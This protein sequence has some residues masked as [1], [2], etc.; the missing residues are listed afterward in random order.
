MDHSVHTVIFDLDGTL[1]DSAILTL[2]AFNVAAPKYGFPVPTEE[3]IRRATGYANPEFYYILFPGYPREK[4]FE[5]GQFVEQEELRLLPEVGDKLLFSGC[6]ELLVCLRKHGVR[7]HIASTGDHGHVCSILKQTGITSFFDSISCG[8]PDKTEMLREITK[9]GKREGYVMVGDMAKDSTAARANRI[10]SIG[11]CYGYCQAET[12]D[13][14]H[15]IGSPMELLTR[16]GRPM[17]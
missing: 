6:R 7:L 12:S 1:S 8:Q 17:E 5:M 10:V 13:F 16:I 9:D 14:D 4:I 2:H 3:E 15:Y 11:A